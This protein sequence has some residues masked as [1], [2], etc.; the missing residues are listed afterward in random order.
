M[1][2]LIDKIS[3]SLDNG[4]YVLGLYLDFTKAFDT[5]NH[6]ILLQKLE[7][8]GVRGIAL[9]WF[10]SYISGRAQFVDYEG[11]RSYV[12]P[13]NIWIGLLLYQCTMLSYPTWIIV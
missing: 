12:K 5:V 1:I 9:N 6:E 4:D 11:V 2:Y 13:E 7:H 10:K 3:L 8:Y